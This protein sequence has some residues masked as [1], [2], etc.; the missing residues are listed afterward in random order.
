M[1]E[2]SCFMARKKKKVIVE[3]LPED[4]E[5]ECKFRPHEKYQSILGIGGEKG[6]PGTDLPADSLA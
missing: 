5:I 3:D 2:G 4:M 6:K 1:Q